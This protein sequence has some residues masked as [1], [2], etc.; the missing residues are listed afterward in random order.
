MEG[1]SPATLVLKDGTRMTG[2]SFGADVAAAGEV[3]F[4]TGMVGYP[5]ALTD[6]SYRGQILCLTYPL[7]GNY[8]VPG[9]ET[10]EHG[11]PKFLESNK[12]HIRGLIVSDY[13][14]EHS[15][16]NAKRSLG[17][18][19]ADNGVP[20][21][22]GI[23]TR[24]LTMKLREEGAMLGKI[25]MPSRETEFSDPNLTNLV[26]EVSTKV[27]TV[28]GAGNSPRILA[29]D[30]GMKY[31]IIRYFINVLKVELIVVPFDHDIDAE[32]GKYDG[33]FISNGPGNP[34]MAAATIE[35]IK[36]VLAKED[37]KPIFG[38]CLGNQLL[39][40][41]AGAKTYKMKYG[42]RGM[43]QPCIDLRTTK[44]YIT[45]QNHGFAVDDD[46][47]P[48]GWE[49]FFTN[50]NDMTN[51]GIIHKF[52]PFFSVQFHPEA[53]GG[54]TD[55]A[56]LFDMFLKSV[57]DLRMDLTV[58]PRV[59][60]NNLKTKVRKCIL[61]GSGGLS[62]GQAGEFDYSGSQAIKALKEE[63]IEVILINPNIATVQTSSGFADKVYFLPVTADQVLEVIKKEKPDSILVSMGGQTA[64]NVGV[65]LYERGEL[66]K[67]NVRVLGT[68]IPVIVAT[69][70]RELFAE[71][72]AEIN[73]SLAR[74]LPAYNV[75][76]ALAAA[77]EI[78]TL[79][80]CGPRLRWEVSE[81]ALLQTRL[82]SRSS[83]RRR[84]RRQ[85][86]FSSTRI[87]ADGRRLSTKSSA[88]RT[89]TASLCATWK[90]SI[91]SAFTR[92]TPL[93]SRPRRRSPT[94]NTSSCER[95][96][97]RSSATSAS[98]ASATSSMRST[99]Q[100]RGTA[101]SK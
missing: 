83:P 63:G 101:L 95:L 74:T 62:I 97:S 23:D 100:A 96:L 69:E 71:K 1:G 88:T 37:P 47:L 33:L 41:A 3:V 35:Q 22:Y 56:F 57:S 81:A 25:E 2:F 5:E 6:P 34:E 87:S 86:R 7:I 8:G 10:D 28:Y 24:L 13:S 82:S 31:N 77:D 29:Y 72:L 16:W 26:A 18:W 55:T 90:T 11:L 45:P 84:S 44:C 91:L 51:E 15:H 70:D 52:K 53:A 73:E 38:I 43:N 30:C 68:P 60:F 32:E 99:P 50:A 75:A 27:R 19:L 54:P 40:L 64:L 59:M 58:V 65:Q 48:D 46:S 12:V 79:F 61:V 36:K 14:H 39:A 21:I 76:E 92:A 80:S 89:T 67:H 98:S 4:N 17:K 9:D 42:N 78:G 85:T 93:S 49:T 94:A 66:A 20:A